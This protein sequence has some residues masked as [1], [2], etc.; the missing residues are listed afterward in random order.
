MKALVKAGVKVEITE[1][2][3]SLPL[4]VRDLGNPLM[5][6]S[7][8]LALQGDVYR[9]VVRACAATSGCTG[10]TVWGLRDDDTWLDSF[11]QTAASAPHRPLLLNADGSRKPA[12]G[13]LR[14]TLLERCPK[15]G[16]QKS[17]CSTPWPAAVR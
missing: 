10:V 11:S 8:K 1:L 9:R 13:A 5:T 17:P 6:E 14:D 2:D 16:R 3:V 4:A 7:Q 12:Y 15:T